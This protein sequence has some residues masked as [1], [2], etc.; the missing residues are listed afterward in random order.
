MILYNYKNIYLESLVRF[1]LDRFRFRLIG[2]V[3][4]RAAFGNEV[5]SV[6]LAALAEEGE[7]TLVNAHRA[8]MFDSD[9]PAR[10]DDVAAEAAVINDEPL[11]RAGRPFAFD[12]DSAVVVA[13]LAPI[14][15]FGSE[16]VLV[17]ERRVR[18]R[19]RRAVFPRKFR[20]CPAR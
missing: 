15:V 18:R 13:F 2:W 11:V 14:D 6:R 16:T 4:G 7:F 5:K 1:F 9:F 10:G 12:F 19:D 17:V 20:N 8:V 3:V